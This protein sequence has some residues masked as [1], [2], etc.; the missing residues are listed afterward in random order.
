MGVSK[1]EGS[2]ILTPNSR[3]L[4]YKDTHTEDPQS[5]E[6]AIFATATR[7]KGDLV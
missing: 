2:T 1:N 5:V 4:T 7:I 6:I 3:A